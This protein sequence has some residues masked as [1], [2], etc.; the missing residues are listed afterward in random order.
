M[1]CWP[2]HVPAL[3]AAAERELELQRAQRQLGKRQGA[4]EASEARLAV[5]QRELAA[6]QADL[7][8]Q[9]QELEALE[10]QL[11]RREEV[12]LRCAHC[13][14]ALQG[15]S[16]GVSG[17][18]AS[19]GCCSGRL[20]GLL[21]SWQP[22]DGLAISGDFPWPH[23]VAHGMCRSF[24]RCGL[25]VRGW[26]AVPP[27]AQRRRQ[28][29]TASQPPEAVAGARRHAVR[30]LEGQRGG[31]PR[32][33]QRLSCSKMMR[34]RKRWCSRLVLQRRKRLQRRLRSV[35]QPVLRRSL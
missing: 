6:Q 17:R 33:R 5:Q 8:E 22:I 3:P 15:S 23:A 21:S 10:L 24:S 12:G 27:P 32:G 34:G 11:Q 18:R 9:R 25:P 7:A 26:M 30:P 19:S 2:G 16:A 14:A 28:A 29:T 13:Q 31:R 20:P 35:R 4:V 1:T